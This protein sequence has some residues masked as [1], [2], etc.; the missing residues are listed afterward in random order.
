MKENPPS[1]SLDLVDRARR[2]AE[3]LKQVKAASH[4]RGAKLSQ[5]WSLMKDALVI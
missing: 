1:L 2:G 4:A 5:T 3:T